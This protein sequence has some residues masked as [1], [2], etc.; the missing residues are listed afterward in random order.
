MSDSLI[1]LGRQPALGIAELESIYGAARI[2]PVSN[3]AALAHIE[4]ADVAFARLGSAVKLCKYLTTLDTTNWKDIE[5]Y[6]IQT[7]VER[8]PTVPEG[9]MHLGLSVYGLNVSPQSLLATGL[10]LKKA[11]QR[12]TSKS[13]R[14]VPNKT[15][16]LNAAQVLHNKLLGETG[17]E[18]VAVQRG[19]QT[20]LGQTVDVQ[21]ID[22]YAARDHGRPKRDAKVGMLPPKLAQT[23]V[24]LAVGDTDPLYGAV[25]L[26]PFCGTGVVLQEATLMGFDVYGSDLD[27]RMVDYTDKNLMWLLGQPGMP[28][29]YSPEQALPPADKP[30]WRYFRLEQGDATTHCW[31]PSPNFVAS[32]TY[33]GRPFTSAPTPEVLAQTISECNTILK[34]FL[35]NIHDQLSTPARLCIAVPAWQVKP[36]QF[37]HL[38]LI[39][40]L[41]ELGYNQ[42]RF[43][44]VPANELLYYRP[45]QLV[46]RELL[47]ITRK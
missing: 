21:A 34:K 10:R 27:P 37:R 44:H 19:H 5:K 13:V 45:D 41:E 29:R 9:K 38:P 32:E 22:A 25:V 46:A 33:L 18:F 3:Q 12:E 16:D 43:E 40:Q 4:P 8:A 39:D 23:I 2:E 14:L 47:V 30:G 17:W 24:N 1:I 35:Q 15:A 7:S 26:D 36:G 20:L 31:S 6:L 11:I 28:V 42:I